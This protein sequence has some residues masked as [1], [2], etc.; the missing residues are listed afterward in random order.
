VDRGTHPA[1]I[2]CA[3]IGPARCRPN[4]KEDGR[5]ERAVMKP[6]LRRCPRRHCKMRLDTTLL[7][8]H[9]REVMKKNENSVEGRDVIAE[10]DNGCILMRARLIARVLTALYDEELR[11]FGIGSPQFALLVIIFGIQ[12]ATRAEIGRY[13]HQD[14]STLTRNLKILL[15]EGWAEELQGEGG[16]RG[17]PIALTKA[18]KDLL[19]EGAPTWRVAQARAKTLLG[20]NGT[21]AITEIANDIMNSPR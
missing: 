6:T 11:P 16:G 5:P 19:V 2:L 18:G 17:R 13:Y 15:S 7:Y 1:S 9:H 21:A 3:S 10:I 14:R 20:E 12:P 4:A 8:M